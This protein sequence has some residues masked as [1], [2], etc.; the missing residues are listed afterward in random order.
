MG[1]IETKVKV[2]R[3]FGTSMVY[4]AAQSARM[5]NLSGRLFRFTVI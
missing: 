3:E 1:K 5:C 4:R 2:K